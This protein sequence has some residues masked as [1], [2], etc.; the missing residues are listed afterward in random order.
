MDPK[1]CVIELFT[2][3]GVKAKLDLI[4]EKLNALNA[5][6]ALSPPVANSSTCLYKVSK[7]VYSFE[8]T[9][10]NDA[11][12][13]TCAIG[14]A[15]T[16]IDELNKKYCKEHVD[17]VRASPE[18]KSATSIQKRALVVA[19]TKANARVVMRMNKIQLVRDDFGEQQLV[20]LLSCKQ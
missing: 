4:I 2:L 12:A 10:A 14:V 1:D 19:C 15:K 17:A 5:L 13:E 18:Y 3:E 8:R 20:D 16:R 7:G 9:K 11:I 6:N